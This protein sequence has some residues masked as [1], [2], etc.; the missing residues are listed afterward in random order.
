MTQTHTAPP[1]PRVRDHYAP[2]LKLGWP[3]I[4][5]QLGII[6]VAF[7][8]NIMI[9]HHSLSELAGASF[10]NNFLNL[11]IIFGIGISYGLTPLVAQE[12]HLGH[13]SAL[14]AWFYHSLFLNGLFALALG[15]VM[16]LLQYRLSW[17]NVEAD[18]IPLLLPYYRIQIYGFVTTMF[19]GAVKQLMDGMHHTAT[20]MILTVVGNLL[21]IFL[22][23]LLI[24]GRWGFPELGLTGA[25]IATLLSRIFMLAAGLL[26]LFTS[27]TYRDLHL[28]QTLRQKWHISAKRLRSL[29]R[30]GL[31]VATQMGLEA[32]SFSI[33]VIFV[34][35]MGQASLATFQIV[36]TITT[37]G[38]LV[39]YGFGSATTIRV[40]VLRTQ[41]DLPGARRAATA[42]LRLS[43]LCG[44]AAMLFVF[45][46]DRQL[47]ALFNADDQITRMVQWGLLGIYLFQAGDAL[48]VIYS[49]A[50][51]GLARVRPLAPMA[52]ICHI[53]IAPTLAY[54]FPFVAA[55]ALYG[56]IT[57]GSPVGF[58]PHNT[59]QIWQHT[60]L[61]LAFPFSLTTLGLL[62]RHYFNR[63]TRPQNRI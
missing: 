54:L 2:T 11:A 16:F 14:A 42:S 3:I 23:W 9:S 51:R 55:P 56:W 30:I 24:Y 38:F 58:T 28:L 5:G 61:W 43:F 27:A 8:D 60:A 48:Q 45:L 59:P 39:Y 31:P 32:T 21:N 49:N 25:G 19:F 15:L 33:A 50:L 7:V 53:L 1:H 34:A 44:F 62:L 57:A 22:N 4:V 13:K 46:F 63:Y 18:L 20:P 10:V 29:L 35:R 26:I 41:G 40:S 12:H 47:A 37:L 17:F 36:N 52:F 6:L